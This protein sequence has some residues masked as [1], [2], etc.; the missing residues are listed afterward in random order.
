M[1][2][3]IPARGRVIGAAL[4]AAL[5]SAVSLSALFVALAPSQFA[6]AGFA[7]FVGLPIALLHSLVIGVPAYLVM[8]Q[9]GALTWRRSAIGGFA[10][11]ALPWGL[12][13]FF[14]SVDGW[15][16]LMTVGMMGG[17]GMIGGLAF[18]AVL[19]P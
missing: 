10:V 2:E 7:F 14:V 16:V 4:M 9:L 17:S 15:S 13:A 19:R 12:F 1:V 3:S 8:R 18:A 6:A 11:G 5:A